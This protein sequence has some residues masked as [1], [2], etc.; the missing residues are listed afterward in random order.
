MATFLQATGAALVGV[1]LCMMRSTKGKETGLLLSMGVCCMLCLVA[2]Q[3]LQ[4]VI[5]FLEQLEELGGLDEN[6]VGILLK[7]AG[8]GFLSEI[9][10]LVCEDAGNKSMGKALQILGT[11]VILWLSIPLFQSL[12]DLISQILGD[13]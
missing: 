10:G 7:A 13:V 11:G 5:A 2:M 3:Y 4:P 8:I 1:V 9:A 12:L 6:L